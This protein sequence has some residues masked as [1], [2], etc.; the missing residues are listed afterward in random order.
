M[1]N[2]EGNEKEMGEAMT[3]STCSACGLRPV[4]AKGQRYCKACH[5]E[6][7]VKRQLA[8]RIRMAELEDEV[9]RLRRKLESLA[10]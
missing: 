7:E 2:L 1:G 3:R 10:S 8:R 6:A 9:E 4:R 5:T